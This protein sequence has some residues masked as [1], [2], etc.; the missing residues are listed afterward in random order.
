MATFDFTVGLT[1]LIPAKQ[2]EREGQRV[3]A[4]RTTVSEKVIPGA[5][6]PTKKEIALFVIQFFVSEKEYK[7]HDIDNMAKTIMDCL[8]GKIY[9]DDAQVRT[10]LI[11]K[12]ISPKVSGNFVFIGIKELKGETDVEVVKSMLLQQAIVFYQT[13]V[14]SSN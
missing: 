1:E 2:D 14:K 12:K 10:L 8:K 3:T 11:T 13:L 4:F 6:F 9:E 7:T 5:P